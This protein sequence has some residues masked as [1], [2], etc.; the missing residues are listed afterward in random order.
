MIDRKTRL[1][2]RRHV[3]RSKRQVEDLGAQAEDHLERNFFKRLP[4]LIGV[5]RFVLGWLFLFAILM[6]GVG[7]QLRALDNYYLDLKPAAGGTYTEGIVGTFT[8]ANPLYATSITDTT[9]S[10]LI[11]AGLLKYDSENRLVGDLADSWKVSA[12][13]R[14]YTVVLRPDLTWQ[15]GQKLTTDDVAFT[16]QTIQNPDAKS[17]LFSG[18]QG[19]KIKV[20]SPRQITFTLPGVLASFPQSLTTGIVPKHSLQ[21]IPPAQLRSASFNTARPVGAGPFKWD[22]IE[23]IASGDGQA[24]Q[25]QIGLVAFS[26]YHRGPAK[27]DQFVIKTYPTESMLANSFKEGEVNAMVGI[28]RLPDEAAKLKDLEEYSIPLTAETMV[29]L[30]TDSDV[31]KDVKVRR[32]L[33][34]AVNTAE[35]V[36]GLGYPVVMADEPLLRGQLGYNPSTK[37]LSYNLAEAKKLLDESGWSQATTGQVRKKGAIELT[38]RLYAPNNADYAAVSQRLQKAWQELGVKAEVI[39]PD[40]QDLQAT[41]S[42]R[43]YDILLYGISIGSDPDVFAY[44]HSSQADVRSVTRLNFSNYKSVAADKALEGGRTRIDPQ[45][46]AAKYLPFLQAW[47]ADAPAI[48]L[49]QP[50]FYYVTHERVFGLDNKTVNTAADRFANVQNWMI[51]QEPSLKD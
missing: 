9:V 19:V 36:S 20:D 42:G 43:Q 15:D 48:A 3:R 24:N 41:I 47:R 29:F 4:R 49:Y 31:L 8:N 25:Q 37:Q 35:A 45:L 13:G 11:F 22:T 33:V 23:I 26:G 38:M 46:R 16:F 21:G 1:K 7:M 5:K 34:Q 17:P 12:D 14:S 50:R 40:E 51:T 27:I 28:E 18:L 6:V 2:F 39:L 30:R 32:A 10:R 44:W